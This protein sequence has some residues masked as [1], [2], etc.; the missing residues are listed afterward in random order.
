MKKAI[1]NEFHEIDKN[2]LQSDSET[3]MSED[4]EEDIPLECG[5]DALCYQCNNKPAEGKM[6]H[7]WTPESGDAWFCNKCKDK[8]D[9][10]T[11]NR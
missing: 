8:L 1:K 5:E 6:W 4:K 11:E 10:I 9:S 3:T 7:R 2:K